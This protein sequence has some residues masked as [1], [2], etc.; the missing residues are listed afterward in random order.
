MADGN[1]ANTIR[2]VG[3]EAEDNKFR[4]GIQIEPHLSQELTFIKRRIKALMEELD[5]VIRAAAKGPETPEKTEALTLLNSLPKESRLILLKGVGKDD[6]EARDLGRHILANAVID[7]NGKEVWTTVKEI[8]QTLE[9]WFQKSEIPVDEALRGDNLPPLILSNG[10]INTRDLNRKRIL[11]VPFVKGYRST[12]EFFKAYNRVTELHQNLPEGKSIS[13][14]AEDLALLRN[15]GAEIHRVEEANVIQTIRVNKTKAIAWL[16]TIFVQ[17]NEVM[18]AELE[19][20]TIETIDLDNELEVMGL[21]ELARTMFKRDKKADT[22]EESQILL[23]LIFEMINIRRSDAYAATGPFREAAQKNMMGLFE[24]GTFEKV[25]LEELEF[26]DKG[27]IVAV[28]P[29]RVTKDARVAVIHTEAGPERVKLL[30]TP[31]DEKGADPILLKMMT[32]EASQEADDVRDHVRSAL[33]FPEITINDLTKRPEKK[34]L[35]KQ[36]LIAAGQS[37][38]LKYVPYEETDDFKNLKPGQF[39][40]ED[41]TSEDKGL[42]KNMKAVG[43]FADKEDPT[44]IGTTVEI[45][46][47]PGDLNRIVEG[48]NSPFAHPEYDKLRK[49]ETAKN[50]LSRSRRPQAHRALNSYIAKAKQRRKVASK[51]AEEWITQKNGSH[52]SSPDEP[53]LQE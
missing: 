2:R 43:I 42:F 32:R 12:A 25:L 21:M 52:S 4:R 1:W 3:I 6:Q 39:T 34:E 26:D 51:A 38:G 30:W 35:V 47:N 20:E 14:E 16:K 50:I 49:A 53:A 46:G 24:K 10:I 23:R 17:T 18:K 5:S 11:K 48:K 8:A 28:R 29:D 31:F 40:V 9:A 41:C 13:S 44:R 15:L 33:E 22:R 27:N 37:L 45:Q 36:T 7:P 19:D